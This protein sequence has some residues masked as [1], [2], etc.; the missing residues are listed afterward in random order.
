MSSIAIVGKVLHAEIVC[1]AALHTYCFSSQA[2]L[3]R[4]LPMLLQTSVYRASTQITFPHRHKLFYIPGQTC[5]TCMNT[6]TG[7]CE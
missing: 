6:G 7:V 3:S 2:Q 4:M 1:F 5:D